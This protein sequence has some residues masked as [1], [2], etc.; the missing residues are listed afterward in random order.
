MSE[1]KSVEDL[2]ALY[3]E[4]DG[5][6]FHPIVYVLFFLGPAT[7]SVVVMYFYLELEALY[8]GIVGLAVMNGSI[9]TVIAYL[10]I[11]LDDKSSEALEHLAVINQEMDKLETTLD[12]ANT[13]VSSFTGDLDEA[14]ARF[15]QVGLDL[16]VIDDVVAKLAEN[17]DSISDLLDSMKDM[18]V[19]SHLEQ[20]KTIEWK[21]LLDG[22]E[23]VLGFMQSKKDFES[24]EVS[25]F[26]DMKP[27]LPSPVIAEVEE[28]YEEVPEWTQYQVADYFEEPELEP[29]PEP[30]PQGLTLKRLPQIK[31]KP[32]L[33]LERRR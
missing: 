32:S 21:Q 14:K 1:E 9:N 18:D 22:V 30:E 16:V 24:G 12:E 11:R 2:L 19:S 29:E 33:N 17:K 20:A 5:M 13:M 15:T 8:S 6:L 23:E 28:D 31:R 7:V 25:T 26:S 4:D 27:V 10:T 3:H